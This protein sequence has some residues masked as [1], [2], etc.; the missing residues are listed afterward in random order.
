MV[1]ADNGLERGQWLLNQP[2]LG[3]HIHPMVWA[4]QYQ[5]TDNA[6][7]AVFASHPYDAEDYI[8]DYEDFLKLVKAKGGAHE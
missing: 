7:L 8:R 5:Y 4:A 1:S 3:L 2:G 6:V